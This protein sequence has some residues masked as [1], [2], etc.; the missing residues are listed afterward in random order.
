MSMFP[1]PFDDGEIKEDRAM[2]RAKK[3]G[4]GIL[5]SPGAGID[6]AF[7][8]AIKVFVWTFVVPTF[9]VIIVLNP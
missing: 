2:K 5:D 1:S 9:F 3:V 7:R 8:F 4:Q 6:D